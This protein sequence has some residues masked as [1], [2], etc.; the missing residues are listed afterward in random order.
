MKNTKN[1]NTNKSNKIKVLI[2]KPLFTDDELNKREGGLIEIT[3]CKKII[4]KNTDAY[5]IDEKTGKKKLLFKFR[6]NVIPNEICINA[7][8]ALEA[9]A[10]KKNSNRGA[11]AGKLSMR[12]LPKNVGSII[13]ADKF[14]VFYKTKEGKITKDNVG[15]ISSSNIAGY[16]DKPDRNAYTKLRKQ[17][18]NKT[19]TIRNSKMSKKASVTTDVHGVPM[20]RMT[21]F[22][23]DQPEKWIQVIPLVK[24]INK[25]YEILTPEYYDVQM[26]R[27]SMVPKF[28]IADTAYSTIT[29]NYDWRTSI[30]KDKNDYDEGF[31][32]L[33]VLE[34]AKSK[35]Q[36]HDKPND[37]H[38]NDKSN[39]PDNNITYKGGYL[40]FPKFGVGIDVRQTDTLAMDVHQYHANTEIIGEGRLSVVCYLRKQM[41][42]CMKK[43]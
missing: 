24:E 28:Q 5:Y 26:K 9:H 15:N 2:L 13:K 8:N 16:Y 3:D 41:I 18:M 14:R 31:G 30:H 37:K 10:K 22:T 34:K 1:H 35:P 29:V 40:V 33:T 27:A 6:K 25:Q 20:C 32:N 7:Y 38:N 39:T 36:P 4:S 12:R 21:K 42:N 17:A 23:R 43:K 11:A 19:K